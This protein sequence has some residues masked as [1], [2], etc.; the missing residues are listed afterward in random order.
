MKISICCITYNHE[1]YIGDALNGFLSQQFS[2]DWEIVI[3]DDAS[4]DNTVKIIESYIKLHP[5]RIRLT[6]N[7]RNIGMTAN[8]I[9]AI[10]SCKG[11][12]IAFCE[13]DDYWTDPYKLQKQSAILDE[14]RGCS[15]VWSNYKF[16]KDQELST[17]SFDLPFENNL[18]RVDLSNIFEPYVSLTLTAM[19]R[20]SSLS[21]A[22][23]GKLKYFRDNSL[24][25]MALTKG[26]GLHLNEITG[27]YRLHGGG[28]HS[29]QPKFRQSVNNYLV[30]KEI[31]K[32]FPAVKV[33]E[34][35]H[36]FKEG[37]LINSYKHFF[38][39]LNWHNVFSKDT[40]TICKLFF[41]PDTFMLILRIVKSPARAIRFLKK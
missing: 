19:V 41:T 4:T 31:I 36:R 24:Y 9:Q 12:Y 23:I 3:H 14:N 27:V 7:K 33:Y 29:M 28:T 22:S 21:F 32:L 40:K 37:E 35:F 2:P 17:P 18:Y 38:S 39:K 30:Y 10:N 13:G 6:C 25:V 1:K 5:N 8:F 26:Y 20:A 34:R 15:I 11:E 16:L